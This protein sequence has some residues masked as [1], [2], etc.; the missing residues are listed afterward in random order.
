M[1]RD[2]LKVDPELLEAV[3]SALRTVASEFEHAGSIT[4]DYADAMGH[5][6]VKSKINDFADKWKIKR[7]KMSEGIATLGEASEGIGS[8]FREGDN[9]MTLALQGE[10]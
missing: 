6:D 7:A 3:G 9:E 2:V 5:P 4:D 1:A 10:E 8:A